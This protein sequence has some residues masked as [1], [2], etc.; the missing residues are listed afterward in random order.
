[1]P[2]SISTYCVHVQ[3]Y[4]KI[5]M[6]CSSTLTQCNTKDEKRMYTYT[7]PSIDTSAQNKVTCPIQREQ[8]VRTNYNNATSMISIL[9]VDV[10]ICQLIYSNCAN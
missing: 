7:L 8:R 3:N 10:M 4:A 9:S 5:V 1:M 6:L 2:T